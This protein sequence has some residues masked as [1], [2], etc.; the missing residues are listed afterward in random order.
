MAATRVWGLGGWGALPEYVERS[1]RRGAWG[2]C[3]THQAVALSI[4]RVYARMTPPAPGVTPLRNESKTSSSV[5]WAAGTS[6]SK[7]SS[8]RRNSNVFGQPIVHC[9]MYLSRSMRVFASSTPPGSSFCVA[10]RS[11]CCLR[12]RALTSQCGLAISSIGRS[13]SVRSSSAVMRSLFRSR[14]PLSSATRSGWRF[15][16]ETSS[17]HR[18]RSPGPLSQTSPP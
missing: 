9:S 2:G 6:R 5:T 10:T 14:L 7:P 11:R 8:S 17:W 3:G 16:S 1:R 18:R 12:V 4:T 15:L 13:R